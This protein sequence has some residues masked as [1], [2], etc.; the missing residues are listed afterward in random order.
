MSDTDMEHRRQ[1]EWNE[2]MVETRLC[3]LA[4]NLMR[5]SRGSG[6]LYEVEAQVMELAELFAKHR[7]LTAHGI[8]QDIFDRALS[9]D[10]YISTD[11]KELAD[12]QHAHLQIV[13]GALQLAASEITDNNTTRHKGEEQLRQGQMMWEELRNRRRQIRR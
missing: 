8:P 13:K 2:R 12:Y 9:Y 6:K 10:P 3:Q 7:S 1:V 4:A 11:D 5:I